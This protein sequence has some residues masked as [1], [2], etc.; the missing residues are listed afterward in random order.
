MTFLL[1]CQIKLVH[2]R[3]KTD[4][5]SRIPWNS[6]SKKRKRFPQF[7]GQ[8]SSQKAPQEVGFSSVEST[9][10]LP[11][12]PDHI[13]I[14]LPGVQ[15]R[16]GPVCLGSISSFWCSK[17]LKMSCETYWRNPAITRWCWLFIPLFTRFS[18][19]QVLIAGFLNHQQ[20]LYYIP[21]G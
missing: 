19:S 4:P 7:Q 3:K 17:N 12:D 9:E 21:T 2:V 16:D 13:P 20:Y 10:F 8:V 5:E 1:F 18:T 6:G 15:M 14:D 11:P